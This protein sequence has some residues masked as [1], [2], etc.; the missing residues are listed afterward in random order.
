MF[1]FF[2]LSVRRGLLRALTSSTF[3]LSFLRSMHLIVTWQL[4]CHILIIVFNY[5]LWSIIPCII[6]NFNSSG[7]H[8]ICLV[9]VGWRQIL[10]MG[11]SG[12]PIGN[13]WVGDWVLCGLPPVSGSTRELLSVSLPASCSLWC[14]QGSWGPRAESTKWFRRRT[15]LVFSASHTLLHSSLYT[16]GCY[17]L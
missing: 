7:L 16:E 5:F 3:H 17:N 15:I 14:Q 6:V 8:Y 12:T 11:E 4:K 10:A 1:G 13:Q 9:A 2:S